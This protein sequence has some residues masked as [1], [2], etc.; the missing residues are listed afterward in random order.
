MRRN[1]TQHVCLNGLVA[2][3]L[4]C[5]GAEGRAKAPVPD[6]DVIVY[7]KS[8]G[9]PPSNPV[10][11]QAK[12]TAAGMFAGIGVRVAWANEGADGGPAASVVLH[13]IITDRPQAG[14]PDGAVAFAQPFAGGTKA[15]TIMWTLVQARCPNPP[16]LAP[17]LLAHVMVHEIAH[18]LGGVDYHSR[19][20]V[21]KARWT[22]EDYR[23]ML[24]K[25]L[26]F[27]EYDVDV[28]RSGLARLRARAL[29]ADNPR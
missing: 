17:T 21:M 23:A 20:G 18:V 5:G 4:L 16:S 11:A 14:L 25:P 1:S 8:D 12:K 10:M 24:W 9:V 27:T 13:V 26:P 19:A 15:I 6:P 22:A 29:A 7:L 3:A 2:A 28:I